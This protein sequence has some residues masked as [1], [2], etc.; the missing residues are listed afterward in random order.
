MTSTK[1]RILSVIALLGACGIFGLPNSTWWD[2]GGIT[3][4]ILL[5]ISIAGWVYVIYQ[6]IKHKSPS[7]KKV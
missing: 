3:P 7:N 4:R 6:M 1:F 2:E 5:G